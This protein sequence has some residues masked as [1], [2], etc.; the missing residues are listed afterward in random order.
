LT[1]GAALVVTAWGTDGPRSLPT[2]TAA[3]R[4]KTLYRC[5]KCGMTYSEAD[6]KQNHFI[7]PMDGGRLVPVKGQ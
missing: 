5:E 1:D 4:G 2:A 7:D 6:A 3:S